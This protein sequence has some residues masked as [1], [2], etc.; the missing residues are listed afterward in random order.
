MA[1]LP[2]QVSGRIYGSL[3]LSIEGITWMLED[4][5]ASTQVSLFPLP[6]VKRACQALI[7]AGDSFRYG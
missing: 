6:S 1:S 4:P 7:H 5:P 3:R 2:P